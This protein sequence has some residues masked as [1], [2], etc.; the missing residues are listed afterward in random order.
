MKIITC[1]LAWML[2]EG[3][4][5]TLH[6]GLF[7]SEMILSKQENRSVAIENCHM[8]VFVRP[9]TTCA[10]DPTREVANSFNTAARKQS[11]LMLTMALP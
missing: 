9:E 4:R 1:V 3:S 6:R 11:C 8:E 10:A 5:G 7:K 2:V